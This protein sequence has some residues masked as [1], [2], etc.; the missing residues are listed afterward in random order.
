MFTNLIL[1]DDQSQALDGFKIGK[2]GDDQL[3]ADPNFIALHYIR[4]SHYND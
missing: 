1:S 2:N 3:N 4:A